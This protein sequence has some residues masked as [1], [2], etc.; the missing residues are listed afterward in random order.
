MLV[1]FGVPVSNLYN[2]VKLALLEKGLPF[3]EE[4]TP[5]SQDEALL[6]KSPM[7][8]VPFLKDGDDYL[9][10]STAIVEYLDAKYPENPLIPR[11]PLAAARVRQNSLLVEQYVDIPARRVLG[12]ALFGAERDEKLI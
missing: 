2:K 4:M 11:D 10:E 12:M 1:L 9:C 5:P 7:G 3:Q 6:E 8:K